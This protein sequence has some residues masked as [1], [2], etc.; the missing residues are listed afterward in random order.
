MKNAITIIAVSLT[1]A[2]GAEELTYPIVD[3]G[4]ERCF[5]DLSEMTFPAVGETYF[6]Q[7]ARYAGNRPAYEDN[8]DGTVTDLVTGL[9]WQ[10]N[11]GSK[12]TFRQ[13]VAHASECNTGAYDD[14]RLPSIKELYSLILFSGED[15]DPMAPSRA[16]LR[17]F[18]DTG[19]FDF[20]YGDIDAGERIIDS[21]FATSTRYLSTTM[22]GNPTVFGVNFADGRIKG[23]PIESPRGE[24][25]FYVLYVRGNSDYGKNDFVDNGDGTVTD[26]ATG[27]T[28]MTVDS[29]HLKAG[30]KRD[31]AL[32]WAEALAW[33]ETLDYAGYTDWRLPN[34]KELQSLIDYTRCPDVTDSAALDPI[35]EA[36]A[37]VNEGGQKDY[38][39]YWS[40]TT[41]IRNNG[42][43]S[44]VYVCFGRGLGFMPD[45]RTGER[46][47]MDVHGAG[48]QRSDPKAGDPAQFPFGR[49]PQGDVLRIYNMV[50][51]V[52]G[53]TAEP[54]TEGPALQY[55]NQN[56]RGDFRNAPGSRD[57]MRGRRT[58]RGTVMAG[59][60]MQR[61]PDRPAGGFTARL[62]RSGDG[63][64]SR[65]EFDGPP[66]H[67][68][69]LD[70]NRDGYLTDD[71]APGPPPG[72]YGNSRPNNNRIRSQRAN[73]F[74]QAIDGSLKVVT[75]GTGGPL[76]HPNRSSP[77]VMVEY[78][79][80]YILVDMGDGTARHLN[81]AG[82][83]WNSLAAV[84]FTHHHRDHNADA[85]EILPLLWQRG[86][87]API[88]GPTQT[89][90]LVSFLQAFFQEDI[91]YRTRNT[92][93]SSR[94]HFVPTAQDVTSSTRLDIAG[95]KATVT[96]VTHSI[97]T[98]AWRFDSPTESIVI[99]GDL[100][101]SDSLIELA[102][103]CDLLVI[104]SG[105]IVYEGMPDRPRR[106]NRRRPS[107]GAA[108][109]SLEEVATMA[110]KAKAGKLVLVH[111]RPG[112]VDE[113]RTVSRMRDIYSGEII[114]AQ[115]MHTYNAN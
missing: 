34:A 12:M 113:T 84:C 18:I 32:N 46:Q 14:W 74:P 52:R 80:K 67:F 48:C 87:T 110:A 68:D 114:F 111:F 93:G 115:D 9:M 57:L 43:C 10:K 112:T 94:T 65:R 58:G 82:F 41:H 40:S 56:R 99:S 59:P 108:H 42:P 95:L 50:R 85:M 47:L 91:A 30:E 51:C 69:Q 76:Y 37:I 13:A 105:G 63:K 5:N 22:G 15:P 100:S 98:L 79:G 104:D 92:S 64:V 102:E 66:D 17:P 72:P 103:N 45:R 44:G 25:Q 11:P 39:H 86:N 23:Y 71:E 81:E 75:I 83:R 89:E 33:A 24:K 2:L 96:Q 78:Q 21:Q 6:G 77:S 106:V 73:R 1:C 31:G 53:G 4:Q 70:R 27:L 88:Y 107:G 109:A 60:G 26:R 55:T 54:V 38:A 7:D 61:A 3:T 35:L 36:T 62:D 8:G 97:E 16:D 19:Y 20:S 49:G 28:W 29:G 101:Y 90:S